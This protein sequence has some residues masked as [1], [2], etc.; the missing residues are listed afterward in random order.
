MYRTTGR[1]EI[2]KAALESIACQI[3]AV[4]ATMEQDSG[5]SIREMRVDGGPTRNDYLMQLQSDLSRTAVEIADIEELSAAGAAFLAG[6]GA[7]VFNKETVFSQEQRKR[8]TPG[9][10][11]KERH[12]KREEWDRVIHLL[13]Q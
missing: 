2:I 11:E 7:G 12:E 1:N 6:I 3:N 10:S 13:E 4:L 9:M 5:I 8:Y